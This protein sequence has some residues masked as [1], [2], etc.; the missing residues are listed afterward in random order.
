MANSMDQRVLVTKKIL[1]DALLQLMEE[2]SINKITPTELCRKANINRNTFYS[3]YRA[4]EDV[5]H[6]IEDEIL[7][8]VSL[9]FESHFHYH[10][11]EELVRQCCI[12]FKENSD[13]CKIIFSENSESDSLLRMVDVARSTSYAEWRRS[14]LQASDEQLE[15]IF[16]YCA[17]GC[18]S[19]VRF[20]LANGTKQDIDDMAKQMDVACRAAMA[21]MLK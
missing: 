10:S 7:K 8:K 20:W 14:G 5:L 17:G 16:Q 9:V 6:E 12:I 4:P 2:K 13:I 18:V 3:H 19:M 1:R 11:I 15:L 21:A